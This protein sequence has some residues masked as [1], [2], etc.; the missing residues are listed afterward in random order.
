MYVC[1]CETH[2]QTLSNIDDGHT[3]LFNLFTAVNNNHVRY[4]Y[5]HS[6]H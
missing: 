4:T 1:V 5:T 6:I 2:T 3:Q